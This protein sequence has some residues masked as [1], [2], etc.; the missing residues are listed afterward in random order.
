MSQRTE[1]VKS[2]LRQRV[3]SELSQAIGPGSANITVTAIDVSPDLKQATVWLGLLGQPKDQEALWQSAE[4][5]RPDVQAA[6]ASVMTTKF[7]PKLVFKRDLSGD[8]AQHI[9]SIIREL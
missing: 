7:V 5:V 4:A 6:V 2:L 8:Y 9:E 1:K 3:A